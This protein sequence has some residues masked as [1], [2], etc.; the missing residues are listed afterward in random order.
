MDAGDYSFGSLVVGQQGEDTSC[1]GRDDAAREA[2]QADASIPLPFTL[3]WQH[4]LA[5]W[6]QR[7]EYSAEKFSACSTAHEWRFVAAL[8]LCT[9]IGLAGL[10][11]GEHPHVYGDEVT[12]S[13]DARHKAFKDSVYPNYLYLL[14]FRATN[15]FGEHFLPAARTINALCFAGAAP[16]IYAT[17][18]RYTARNFAFLIALLSVAG[19]VSTYAA[20]FMPDAMYFFAF[21]VLAWF[22]LARL[23]WQPGRYGLAIGGVLG[24][25]AM[26]KTHAIFLLPALGGFLLLMRWGNRTSLRQAGIVMLC[27]VLAFAAVRASLG[28]AFAGEAGFDPFGAY[29]QWTYVAGI[30]DMLRLAPLAASLTVA[31]LSATCVL[32]GVAAFALLAGLAKPY[33]TGTAYPLYA[34]TAATLATLLCVALVF[35]LYYA[36]DPHVP[37]SYNLRL[38]SRYYNFTFPLLLMVAAESLKRS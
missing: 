19:P 9:F 24:L 31:H 30:G 37:A 34:F 33:R 2:M 29:R 20:Y 36:L 21:C 35:S 28:F 1:C 17:A 14:I 27:A 22:C 38:F 3:R 5:R 15:L 11:W 13:L 26:I 4:R 8:S 25:M 12:Y 7:L 10:H 6:Q 16:F 32:Y 18:K 23:H